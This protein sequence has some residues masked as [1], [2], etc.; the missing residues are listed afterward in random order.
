MADSLKLYFG[1][2]KHM[3]LR[4][5]L[6]RAWYAFQQQSGWL[7]RRFPVSRALREWITLRDWQQQDARFFFDGKESLAGSALPGFAAGDGRALEK[8]VRAIREGK[9]LFF[10]SAWYVAP[11]W[12]TNPLTGFRYDISR[13]WSE[14]PDF[15]EAAGDIKYVWEKSRFGFVYDLIRYDLHSGADQSGFV[16][17]EIDSWI[18]E[19]PV[20]LGPNWRCSQEISLR[21]LN[22][23][24][25]LFYYRY[26]PSLTPALFRRIVNSI[27]F[28]MQ[29][30]EENISFSRIAVRNNH[31]LTESLAL[32]L[33][34][35]LYPFFPE[36]GRWK[37]NGRRWFEEEIAAQVY[38]DGSYLQFS[39]NYHRVVVQLLSWGIRL[40]ELNG[41]GWSA[42]LME[43]AGSCVRF[44]TAFQNAKTGWLPNYGNNDGALFFPLSEVHFR[45][46]RPQLAALRGLLGEAVDYESGPWEEEFLWLTDGRGRLRREKTAGAVV[47]AFR[48]GGYYGLSTE[49]TLTFIRCGAYRHRPFQAD[50]LHLDLQVGETNILRDAGTYRYNAP[51]HLIEFFS[52]SEGH[53]TARPEG[54][55]QMIRGPR[56]I[57][58]GWV[59]EADGGWRS[60]PDGYVFEG[61]FRGFAQA[62]KRVIHSRKVKKY[63]HRLHWVV[64]D[65]ME[66]LPPGI[67]MVQIWHPDETFSERLTIRARDDRGAALT[68]EVREGW[69]AE[70]YGEKAPAPYLAFRTLSGYIRTEIEIS[71]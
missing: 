55:E 11:G 52:G 59:T 70:K 37:E 22:W 62:G 32:Y 18:R 67:P 16:L 24:F 20:N 3:G 71:G 1:I 48:S 2:L 39:M 65:R 42:G 54:Y 27:F 4:Y 61:W 66:G 53:N 36:A 6:F 29:H 9:I 50:N 40:A 28:Q 13:H 14:I 35:L 38:P 56:F 58:T 30:V 10:S 23:T 57:W 15:S 46:F 51:P 26:S 25:A 7:K 45:D 43:K 41:A 49:D 33:A 19:N 5:V 8:R 63:H 64:E 68:A 21:V 17:G 47:S 69:Y 12:V 31:A 44:L 34:G 60:E